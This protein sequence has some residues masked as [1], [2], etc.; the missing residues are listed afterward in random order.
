MEIGIA[1]SN[2]CI[3]ANKKQQI[4]LVNRGV[5]EIWNDLLSQFQTH[6]E[7]LILRILVGLQNILQLG[8]EIEDTIGA[9]P[10]KINVENTDIPKIL[11]AMQDHPNDRIYKASFRILDKYFKYNECDDEF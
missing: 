7:K 5:I 11:D 2:L 10:I 4:N 9:N 6:D 1:L 3:F 8:E